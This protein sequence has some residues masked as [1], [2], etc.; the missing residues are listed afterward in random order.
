MTPGPRYLGICPHPAPPWWSLGLLAQFLPLRLSS[1]RPAA[2]SGCDPNLFGPLFFC[3]TLKES[4]VFRVFVLYTGELLSANWVR[5]P[6]A[7]E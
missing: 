5:I 7:N 1:K 2:S 6:F 3:S 4:P